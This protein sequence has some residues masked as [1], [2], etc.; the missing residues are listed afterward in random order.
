VLHRTRANDEVH[1]LLIELAGTSTTGDA[2]G[3]LTA[4]E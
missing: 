1:V 2:G 3:E 4:P